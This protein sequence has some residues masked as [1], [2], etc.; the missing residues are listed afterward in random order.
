MVKAM[1]PSDTFGEMLDT[2]PQAR[3]RY[4]ALLRQMTPQQRLRAISSA[5]R[6]IR[7]LAEAGIRRE[8]PGAPAEEIRIRLTV[9]LYG[10]DTA[11]RL[12]GTVPPDAR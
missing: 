11:L 2:T 3:E 7:T 4:H 9:R 1:K 6:G 10:R 8:H 12:H 5:S